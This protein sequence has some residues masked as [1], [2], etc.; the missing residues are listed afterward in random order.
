MNNNDLKFKSLDKVE[1]RLKVQKQ[2][3]P[4]H[5]RFFQAIFHHD[6]IFN[7]TKYQCNIFRM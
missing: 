4:L 3:K 6:W 1:C 5:N 7:T 2:E